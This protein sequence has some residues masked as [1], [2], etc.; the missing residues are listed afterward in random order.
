MIAGHWTLA[1]QLKIWEGFWKQVDRGVQEESTSP[2]WYVQKTWLDHTSLL[3]KP[4]NQK[5]FSKRFNNIKSE[6]KS[7]QNKGFSLNSRGRKAFI[8]VLKKI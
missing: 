1:H 2:A 8:K 7:T 3:D 4:T 5:Q 6:D